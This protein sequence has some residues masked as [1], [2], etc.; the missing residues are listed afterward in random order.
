M[1]ASNENEWLWLIGGMLLVFVVMLCM[2]FNRRKLEAASERLDRAPSY[3]NAL[4]MG[5]FFGLV[6]VVVR[7]CWCVAVLG[8]DVSRHGTFDAGCVFLSEKE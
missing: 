6:A 5:A 8:V 1:L 3:A 7:D 2:R 4:V